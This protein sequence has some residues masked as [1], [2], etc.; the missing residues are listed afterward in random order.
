MPK[1][2]PAYCECGEIAV[3]FYDTESGDDRFL[4]LDPP[5]CPGC[6]WENFFKEAL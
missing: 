5:L 1:Q 2:E 3:F 6:Y 4:L